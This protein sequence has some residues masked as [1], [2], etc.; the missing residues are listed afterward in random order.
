MKE[1]NKMEKGIHCMDDKKNKEQENLVFS[2]YRANTNGVVLLI[3]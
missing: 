2:L 3:N 1:T